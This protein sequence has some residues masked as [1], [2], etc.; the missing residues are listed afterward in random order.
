MGTATV[1]WRAIALAADADWIELPRF[2]RL[3]FL[4]AHLVNPSVTEVILVVK[5]LAVLLAKEK[6]QRNLGRVVLLIV[7]SVEFSEMSPR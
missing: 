3:S 2:R 6:S 7:E 4:V 1:L 5:K